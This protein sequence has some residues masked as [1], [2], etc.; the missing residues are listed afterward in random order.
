MG[1]YLISFLVFFSSITICLI[2]AADGVCS[3][4]VLQLLLILIVF[5]RTK[6]CVSA[7]LV[8]FCFSNRYCYSVNGQLVTLFLASDF[9]FCC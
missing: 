1:E 7:G 8:R 9:F 2:A 6:K 3:I 4:L 5:S